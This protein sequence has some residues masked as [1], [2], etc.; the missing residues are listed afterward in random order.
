MRDALRHPDL[1]S[2]NEATTMVGELVVLKMDGFL[3]LTFVGWLVFICRLVTLCVI[4]EDPSVLTDE[5]RMLRH[6][7]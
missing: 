4:G 5:I 7:K 2:L 6:V 1:A 3:E